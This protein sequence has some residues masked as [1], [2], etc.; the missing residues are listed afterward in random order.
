[1]LEEHYEGHIDYNGQMV[2]MDLNLPS[3]YPVYGLAFLSMVMRHSCIVAVALT[4]LP[5]SFLLGLN[6]V[7][8]LYSCLAFH[9]SLSCTLPA[10]CLPKVKVL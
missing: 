6:H 8:P 4:W 3:P 1:M 2:T 7:S 9:L 5:H 10:P